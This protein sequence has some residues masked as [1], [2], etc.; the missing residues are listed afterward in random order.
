M[1]TTP[2]SDTTRQLIR[3]LSGGREGLT[4]PALPPSIVD[5]AFLEAATGGVKWEALEEDLTLIADYLVEHPV[6]ARWLRERFPQS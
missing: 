1:N 6:F 4:M 5:R 3:F 2:P